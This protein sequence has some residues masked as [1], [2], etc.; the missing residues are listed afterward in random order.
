ML[1][2]PVAQVVPKYIKLRITIEDNGVGISQQNQQKLF[3][4]Y[5]RVQETQSMN[6]KGTG[7]GLM[8]CK[9]IIEQMGGS[10]DIESDE[11]QG[12]KFHITICLKAIDKVI[13]KELPI[14]LTPHNYLTEEF[15]HMFTLQPQ[16]P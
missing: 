6:H 12:T 1:I 14:D 7:L 13:D 10:V 11:G 5:S 2:G 9:Q 4:K 15:K 3:N 16:T 8:I